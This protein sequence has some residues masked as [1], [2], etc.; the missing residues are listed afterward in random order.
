MEIDTSGKDRSGNGREGRGEEEV[1]RNRVPVQRNSSPRQWLLDS[2]A[3]NFAPNFIT[4]TRMG[5]LRINGT[6]INWAYLCLGPSLSPL[7][8]ISP[9]GAFKIIF[10]IY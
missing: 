2:S 7:L 9:N 4:I 8:K 1:N 6:S 10:I 5:P 3:S